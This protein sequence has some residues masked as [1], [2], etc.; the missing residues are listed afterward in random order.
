MHE[1]PYHWNCLKVVISICIVQFE[2]SPTQVITHNL[3]ITKTMKY[4]VYVLR[5][6]NKF[7]CDCAFIPKHL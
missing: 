6:N 7:D 3:I 2:C 4:S 5:Y 1:I